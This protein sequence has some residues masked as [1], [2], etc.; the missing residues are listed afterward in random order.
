M[1]KQSKV[2]EN[3]ADA[4]AGDGEADTPLLVEKNGLVGHDAS[5]IRANHAGDAVEDGGFARARCS[6]ENGE[7]RLRV[8]RDVKVGSLARGA[9]RRP[10]RGREPFLDASFEH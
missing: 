1:G 10:C 2:L 5:G 8:K 4:A 6:E 9:R 7:T 3:V